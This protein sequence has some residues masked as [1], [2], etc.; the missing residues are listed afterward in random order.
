[1]KLLKKLKY[2]IVLIWHSLFRGMADADA[3]IMSPSKNNENGT[4]I[5]QHKNIG[6]VFSDML[7]QKETKQVVETRDK[8]YRVLK[9]SNKW[10]ASNIT[11]IGE[12]ENGVIFS[13]TDGLKKK[14]KLD[15]MKHPPVYNPENLDIRTIQDNKQ[16]QKKNFILHRNENVDNEL[17]SCINDF[18]TTLTIQ[19]DGI[20]PR[21]FIEKYVKRIVVRNLGQRA[22]IDLYFPSEASQ[23]GKI[24]AI[25]I[26]NLHRIKN[27]SITKTDLFDFLSIE[28]YSDKAWNSDDVCHFKYD[29]VKLVGINIF[30]GSFVVTLNCNIIENGTDLSEK[31]KTEELDK[32]YQDEAS[33][34]DAVDFFAFM[35]KEER[36]KENKEVDINNL[37]NT[38][39]KIS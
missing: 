28:W 5:T 34:K 11:I 12:D 24:D 9:E 14:T 13:N 2:G 6:G 25:L 4:N 29:N 27:E 33:K 16:I 31:Y 20:T 15:F 21:F 19:R 37:H 18:E 35:R 39:L 30:D 7:E 23:F 3:I 36:K 26:S 8:Y 1:M 32:K 22:L 17:L 10:D 38:T